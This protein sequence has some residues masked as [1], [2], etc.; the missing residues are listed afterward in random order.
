MMGHV[1]RY[2]PA[3]NKLKILIEEGELGKIQ[4]IYSNSVNIGRIRS[5]PNLLWSFNPRNI[6][7]ILFL[8]DGFPQV[9]LSSG[10]SYAQ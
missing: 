1:F 4:Y 2:H 8:L 6:A 5:K 7:T 3:V 9:I 10:G